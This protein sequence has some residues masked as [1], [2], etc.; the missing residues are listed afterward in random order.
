[1]KKR[2]ENLRKCKEKL[3]ELKND[4]V[5]DQDKVWK[6]VKKRI[7]KRGRCADGKNVEAEHSHLESIYNISTLNSLEKNL[8]NVQKTILDDYCLLLYNQEIVHVQFEVSLENVL[9]IQDDLTRRSELEL[10]IS[11]LFAFQRDE[12][13]FDDE[14]DNLVKEWMTKII[15]CYYK[16]IKTDG[17]LFLL[18][19]ILRCPPASSKWLASFID[20][21]NPLNANDHNEAVQA[22]NFCLVMISTILSPIK[23]RDKFIKY[24]Q[25]SS[26]SINNKHKPS[27]CSNNSQAETSSLQTQKES[28][29]DDV[30]HLLDSEYEKGEDI[31]LNESDL[32]ELDIIQLLIQIPFEDLLKFLTEGLQNQPDDYDGF[33]FGEHSELSILKLISVSTQI[34]RILRQGLLTFNCMKFKTLSDYITLMIEKTVNSVCDFWMKCKNSFSTSDQALILRIQVEYDHFILRS[35]ATILSCQKY[36]VWKFISVIPFDGITESMIW[37]IVWVFYNGRDEVDELDGLAPYFSDS[38]WKSKFNEKSVKLLFKEKLPNLSFNELENLIRSLGNMIKSRAGYEESE[39][40]KTVAID[41]FEISLFKPLANDELIKLT[42]NIFSELVPKHPFIITSL[43]NHIGETKKI[44]ENCLTFFSKLTLSK[45]IPNDNILKLLNKWVYNQDLTNLLN[46][47]SRIILSRLNYQQDEIS[48][49]LFLNIDIQ[50]KISL[51]IYNSIDE[52]LSNNESLE[53]SCSFADC[54]YEQL[55][56]LASTTTFKQFMEWSWRLLLLLKLNPNDQLVK[57]SSPEFQTPDILKD[58]DYFLLRKGIF[59]INLNLIAFR[60]IFFLFKKALISEICIQFTF[61]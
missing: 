58:N 42:I 54:S 29:D 39:F 14:F 45:W 21:P 3:I 1:M 5:L 38:Y 2:R 37:H 44:N 6:I 32:T 7:V 55:V 40:V 28:D 25:P 19:H 4:C 24:N 49:S 56:K 41:M 50:R 10:I 34:I 31:H 12:Q 27:N 26:K 8:L 35:V 48:G 36:G 11:S 15:N 46:Q 33:V 52:H 13:I 59:V 22:M 20:C 18:N 47:L 30:W 17:R 51:I 53:F 16:D 9:N 60:L 57:F 23:S 43:L 61:V